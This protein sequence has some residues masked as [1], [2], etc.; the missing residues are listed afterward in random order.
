[1]INHARNLLLNIR[2]AQM[3]GLPGVE[4]IPPEFVPVRLPNA[5]VQIRRVLFGE[6]PDG[7][8]LNYRTQEL[9]RLIHATDLG[10]F[11]TWRD[12][13]I[14][15]LPFN[16]ALFALAAGGSVRALSGTTDLLIGGENPVEFRGS[17]F[18]RWK[19]TATSGSSLTVD[20]S[21]PLQVTQQVTPVFNDNLSEPFT[22]PNSGLTC[23]VRAITAG[24]SW[25]ITATARPAQDLAILTYQLTQ[26]PADTL[27]WVFGTAREEPWPT[28]RNLWEQSQTPYKLAALLCA[29]I[30]RLDEQPQQVA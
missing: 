13:R 22:L 10:A 28:F 21:Y 17:L 26:L 6:Q 8:K 19:V 2:R 29:Y 7:L 18:F 23:R 24:N 5:A 25:L 27:A 16:D 11:L 1:M 12:D 14:T 20:Q 15:Y 30:W 4:Y 9:L 3:T